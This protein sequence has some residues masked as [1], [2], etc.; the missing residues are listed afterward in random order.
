MF[1][2]PLPSEKARV[3]HDLGFGC[4]DKLFI[5]FPSASAPLPPPSSANPPDPKGPHTQRAAALAA[6][7]PLSTGPP[8]QQN[9]SQRAPSRMGAENH[10]KMAIPTGMV[11]RAGSSRLA[12]QG[13]KAAERSRAAGSHCSPS[14][15]S[16]AQH[17][18]AKRSTAS[19]GS[20]NTAVPE[21]LPRRRLQARAVR[22]RGKLL[23]QCMVLWGARSP[24]TQPCTACA[25]GAPNS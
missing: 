3:I 18:M 11:P 21:R 10:M 17:T 14:P 7:R 8:Q 12:L 9:S 6:A 25:S 20:Q 23:L 5:S 1:Q 2:P 13:P 19:K 24:G 15:R 4:V 22:A 16:Y